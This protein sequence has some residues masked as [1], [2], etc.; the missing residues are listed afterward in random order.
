LLDVFHGYLLESNIKFE[1][2]NNAKT[3]FI[4]SGS[5]AN[6]TQSA[7]GDGRDLGYRFEIGKDAAKMSTA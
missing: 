2:V 5:R 6:P 3:I 7:F 4:S 1:E